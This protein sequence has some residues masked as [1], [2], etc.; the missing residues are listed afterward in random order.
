MKPTA[1]RRRDRRALL[2][3]L[4]TRA[5]RGRL[6]TPEAAL[7]VEQ[8]REEQRAYDQTR[9][10]LGET[11]AAL[12]R[13]R[14]AAK[15]AIRELERR[16]ANQADNFEAQATLIREAE[17][18]AEALL[19]RAE[20]AEQDRATLAT[21]LQA[22][23]A[24]AQE[25]EATAERVRALAAELHAADQER[26]AAADTLAGRL[27]AI[28]QQTAEGIAEGAEMLLHRA[29]QAEQDV[30]EARQALDAQHET[31]E[32][33][34]RA[35]ADALAV[36]TATT[37]PRLVDTARTAAHLAAARGDA[38]A[39]HLARTRDTPAVKPEQCPTPLT[40]NW[41]CGCPT[42]PTTLAEEST[43]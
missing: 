11:T 25:A 24:R 30:T 38:L 36:D 33:R 19:Q 18:R 31:H 1:R 41:G 6:T 2:D 35:L 7:L 20:R 17:Q 15:D 8:V 21:E 16:I 3:H 28:R 43:R 9:A 42:D 32:A 34:R 23:R 29:E 22:V 27:D 39:A 26:Q 4:L 13:H 37:W 10:S 5:L 40:H 12:T 14:A